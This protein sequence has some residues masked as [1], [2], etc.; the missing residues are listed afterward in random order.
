MKTLSPRRLL[1]L[2][3]C[4]QAAPLLAKELYITVRR[5]FG[6]AEAPEVELHYSRQAPFAVRIYRPKDMKEFV[7]SQV[8]LRRPR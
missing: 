2:L 3:L 8:D 7:T 4:L 1:A 5:D 6:P